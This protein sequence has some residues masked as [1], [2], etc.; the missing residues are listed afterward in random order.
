[1]K[2]G[3]WLD[4]LYPPSCHLCRVPLE[5]GSYLCGRCRRD[6]PRITSATCQRCGLPHEGAFTDTFSCPNCRDSNPPYDFA[7]A[8]LRAREGARELIH[9]FKYQRQVHLAADLAALAT[10][11]WQDDRLADC[12]DPILVPVPLHWRRLQ[13]RWFNQAAELARHLS[14]A[15]S[16]P[17]VP[18]LKR[19]RD[20][21]RQMLLSRK[22][23]LRNL[24]GAFRLT[25]R[26]RRRS[27]LMGKTAI[28][29][30]DV[31]TTGSTAAE[32]TRVLRDE[33][34]VEK[35]VVLTVLRG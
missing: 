18:A 17:V 20:T 2:R 13:W 34:G 21:P 15:Q 25:W 32:C 14:K 4:F 26:E 28:L 27:T 6:L 24:Q 30:D 33:A 31:F 5:N 19:V 12:H 16:L 1:M 9:A 29:V 35:V 7:L 23:R 22:D 11:A 8:P 3:R 10:E